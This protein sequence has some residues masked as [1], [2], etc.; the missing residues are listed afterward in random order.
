MAHSFTEHVVVNG[1]Y[2]HTWCTACGCLT[3]DERAREPCPTA[4]KHI[5]GLRCNA[6]SKTIDVPPLDPGLA[7]TL[8][9]YLRRGAALQ[10]TEEM[11]AISADI[12]EVIQTA[13]L[14][15][16]PKLFYFLG[17]SSG[18]GKSQM[19]ESLGFPVVYLPLISSQNIYKCFDTISV[20]VSEAVHE[21]FSL[22]SRETH[23]KLMEKVAS[24]DLYATRTEFLTVGLLVEL[25]RRVWG[26]TNAESIKLLS[27]YDSSATFTYTKM[28]L[29]D[30][31]AAIATLLSTGSAGAQ[32]MTRDRSTPLFMIDEVPPRDT[33]PDK[34]PNYQKCILLR[35]LIRCMNCVCLLCGTE[36]ATMNT[37][38][39]ISVHSRGEEASREYLRLITRLPPTNWDIF[40]CDDDDRYAQVIAALSNDVREMLQRTRPLFAQHVLEVM[41]S[42]SG[43]GGQPQRASRAASAS[44]AATAVA[45]G[46]LTS[47][48]LRLTKQNILAQN[49]RFSRIEGLYAQIM[50]VHSQFFCHSV[51]EYVEEKGSSRSAKRQKKLSFEEREQLMADMQSCV[52]HHYG[53][54]RPANS[55][56]RLDRPLPLFVCPDVNYISVKIQ[57]KTDDGTGNTT[58][59]RFLPNVVF[60]EPCDDEL[61]YLICLRD[62]LCFNQQRVSSSFALR[63]LFRQKESMGGKLANNTTAPACSGR[64][65]ETEV[66]TALVVT[67]HS[68]GGTSG[69][70]LSF[71]LRSLVAELNIDHE[72]IAEAEFTL[73]VPSQCE[74]ICVGLL[75]A[76]NTSWQ[77]EKTADCR[78]MQNESILLSDVNRSANKDENDAAF[79]VILGGEVYGASA[80]MKCHAGNTANSH[81]SGTIEKNGT[82]GHLITIMVVNKGAKITANN[83]PFNAANQ[84]H[85]VYRIRGNVSETEKVSK[86]LTWTV[87]HEHNDAEPLGTVVQIELDTIYWG[88]YERMQCIYRA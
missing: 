34:Y 70:P 11:L 29:Q 14:A 72:Y 54:M 22:L 23:D 9:S 79:P 31:R 51:D 46:R 42:S 45:L 47:E 30:A 16:V 80:E 32:Q 85:N 38:D 58:L 66:I 55:G 65:L 62:G 28:K 83:K 78:W 7:T 61:L 13:P 44:N 57:Q 50:L 63:V 15:S 60:A 53:E 26:K 68:F 25:F 39:N 69:C 4:G 59:Q 74:D 6:Y 56:I 21:D 3:T 73:E 10:N 35:N 77:R 84:G 76:V 88:R 33:D 49:L 87:I 48:V 41:R 24:R 20:A 17:A 43:G 40:E 36:A 8:D 5:H 52:R 27:G 71:L 2:L 64:F 37:I 18:R 19:A 67:S 81:F 86:Q 1:A 75:S 82:N 12:Q